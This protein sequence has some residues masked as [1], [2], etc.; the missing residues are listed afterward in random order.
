MSDWISLLHKPDP[1]SACD[2]WFTRI[3]ERLL[4][5]SHLVVARQ[6]HRLVEIE[7]YYWSDAHPDPFAHRDPIQ[8]HVGHW[9]FHRTHGVYRGGSFKGLDLT[10]GEGHTSGGVLIR[11]LETPNGALIDGPSLCVDYLLDATAAGTVAELDRAIGQRLAWKDGNPLR[12]EATDAL[13]KRSPIRSPRVGLLL[14]KVTARS[15]ST[16]FVMRPYRYLTQ[17]RRT[18]KGKI[19]MVLALHAQGVG[20]EEIHRATNCPRRTIERYRADFEAGRSEADFTPYFGSDLGPA[21]LC[22]LYGVWCAQADGATPFGK[23]EK[24]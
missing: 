23:T 5:G 16:R 2:E 21:E 18:K 9:Y 6:P 17:P 13:D 1:S 15:D 10:F 19:H 24:K 4:N 22:R 20:V 7:I 3:A 8:F 14:K 12:L 11:G